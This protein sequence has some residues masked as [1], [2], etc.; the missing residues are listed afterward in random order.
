MRIKEES[1]R[2]SFQK[3]CIEQGY[4]AQDVA[5]L[6]GISKYTVYAY[7]RGERL[8]NRRTMKKMDEA[9]GID[10]SKLFENN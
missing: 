8:P 4:T 2:N 10:T 6:V 9:F 5:N 7:Y 1:K 3:F